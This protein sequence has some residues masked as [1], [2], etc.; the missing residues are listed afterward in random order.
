MAFAIRVLLPSRTAEHKLLHRLHSRPRMQ[1]PNQHKKARLLTV[2]G[3][4]GGEGVLL[5][6]GFT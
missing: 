3:N 4:A 1:I 5:N 2:C 6:Q